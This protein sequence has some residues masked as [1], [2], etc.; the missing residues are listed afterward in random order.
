[1]RLKLSEEA[2]SNVARGREL[3]DKHTV[4]LID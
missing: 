3:L 2:L 1:M 4:T